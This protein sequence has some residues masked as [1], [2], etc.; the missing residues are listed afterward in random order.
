MLQSIS[1]V[2]R[3]SKNK[4]I[5]SGTNKMIDS[6]NEL[7]IESLKLPTSYQLQSS[8]SIV[9]DNNNNNN[10]SDSRKSLTCLSKEFIMMF[11]KG[12]REIFFDNIAKALIGDVNNAVI[13]SI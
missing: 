4:Y 9:S 2:S 7:K 11:L 5:W 13:K 8:I 10:N 3:D 1:L 6:I 12:E